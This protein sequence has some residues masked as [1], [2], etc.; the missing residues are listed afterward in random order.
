MNFPEYQNAAM[1]TRGKHGEG[2]DETFYFA[3]CAA[4][5]AGE[6]LNKVK[7]VAPIGHSHPMTPEARQEM[8]EEAGDVLWYLTAALESIGASLEDVAIMNITKLAKRYPEGF[9][10]E[11]SIHR[12]T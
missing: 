12:T 11:R 3:G 9:S 7:K 10:S 6:L 5:E 8:L 1:L 2:L 4:G